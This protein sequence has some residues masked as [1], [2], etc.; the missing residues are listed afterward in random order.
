MRYSCAGSRIGRE[1]FE[2]GFIK[3][4]HRAEDTPKRINADAVESI[5]NIRIAD[6]RQNVAT[7]ENITTDDTVNAKTAQIAQILNR[8]EAT[9]RSDL[10][11]GRERLKLIL[12]EAYDFE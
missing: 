7:T 9:V 8:R 11:R 6:A 10:R 12:K 2:A 5:E 4:F 1:K 3:R